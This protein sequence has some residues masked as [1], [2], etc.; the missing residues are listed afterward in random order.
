MGKEEFVSKLDRL[1]D[2]ITEAKE[3]II[4]LEDFYKNVHYKRDDRYSKYNDTPITD[5]VLRS[6]TLT[7]RFHNACKNGGEEPIL[8]L[9]D[10]LSISPKEFGKYRDIGAKCI[11]DVQAFLSKVYRIDWK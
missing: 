11:A 10:L 6:R 4:E 1:Y 2:I 5:I 7:T 9:G 8:T 3:I